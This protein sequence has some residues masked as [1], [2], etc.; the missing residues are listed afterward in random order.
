MISIKGKRGSEDLF[1]PYSKLKFSGGEL[2]V[3]L[4]ELAVEPNRDEFKLTAYLYSSDDI[5]ELFLITNALREKYGYLARVSLVCPYLPFARQDRVCHP[6]EAFSFKVMAALLD[7][8]KYVSV[9]VWDVHNVKPLRLINHARNISAATFVSRIPGVDKMILV[10]PDKG[11]TARV[12]ECQRRIRPIS[13]LIVQ[14]HKERDPD[15]GQ[16]TGMTVDMIGHT[17]RDF[18]LVDDLCDGGR[19]FIELAKLLRPLTTGKIFLYV[20]HGIFSSGFDIFDGLIDHIWT[21]HVWPNRHYTDQILTV[22]PNS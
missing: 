15:T 8:M 12:N 1:L 16:I 5:M 10:A 14:A 21:P 13:P 22:L 11:A 4:S 9:E 2:Q 7:E 18:L 6:G 19:T 17:Q 20:T 3:R